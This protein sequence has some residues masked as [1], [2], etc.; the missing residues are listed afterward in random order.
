MDRNKKEQLL[1]ESEKA[2]RLRKLKRCLRTVLLYT[3]IL[4]LVLYWF[5][6]LGDN[7]VEMLVRVIICF[8]LSFIGFFINLTIFEYVIT[9]NNE[10]DR[11]HQ[12]IKKMLEELEKKERL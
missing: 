11:A 10:D 1:A 5:G 12:T 3:V 2:C 6:Q 4:A 8:I 9:G 7:I